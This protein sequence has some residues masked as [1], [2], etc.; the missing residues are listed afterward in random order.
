[1]KIAICS[2]HGGKKLKDTLVKYLKNKGI[3]IEDF[4]TFSEESCDYVDFGLETAKKV[5]DNT[6]E[7]GI[8]ICSTGIG[9]SIIANKVKGIRCALVGDLLTARLTREHNDSNC[10]A[11]GALIVNEELAK[12]IC[13]IWLNTD[14]TAGRHLRRINKIKDYE[15][16]TNE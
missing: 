11:L 3:I 6:Y 12:N 10:L 4:G 2:D 7:R 9:M 8:L 13:D 15:D 16:N 5:A 14:F 1:M